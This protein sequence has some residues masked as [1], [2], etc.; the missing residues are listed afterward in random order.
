MTTTL[1]A[2]TSSGLVMTPDNSGVIALQN[3]G[4]TA[5]NIDASG[6]VTTPLQPAFF[7]YYTGA[8]T[9]PGVATDA[10][11]VFDSTY[12]N[13]GSNY[14][15]AT[16]RFT[17][18]VA[19]NYYI[20]A[21]VTW[22]SSGVSARYV[23][24]Q[25]WKNDGTIKVLAGH[26]QASNE[27]GDADYTMV[28]INGVVTLAANDYLTVYWATSASTGTVSLAGFDTNVCFSGFLIG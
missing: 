12:T 26:T 10:Q 22:Y 5:L 11:I 6:R 15:T 8:G 2:S 25:V 13:V 16:G 24:A 20:S 1:N 28:S 4:T 3:A 21:C 19:G 18:P 27:S 23:R 14:S 17:A 9:N 7:A